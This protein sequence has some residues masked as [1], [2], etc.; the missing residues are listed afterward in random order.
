MAPQIKWLLCF[1]YRSC[2][3]SVAVQVPDSYKFPTLNTDHV[4]NYNTQNKLK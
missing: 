2:Y 4:L 3:V 1:C